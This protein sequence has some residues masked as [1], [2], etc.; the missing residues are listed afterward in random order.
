MTIA[1][2]VNTHVRNKNRSKNKNYETQCPNNKLLYRYYKSRNY[3][4]VKEDQKRSEIL[5]Y[6]STW[7]FHLRKLQQ[8]LFGKVSTAVAQIN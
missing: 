3:Y 2:H 7:E 5:R 8:I 4:R 6:C 1:L